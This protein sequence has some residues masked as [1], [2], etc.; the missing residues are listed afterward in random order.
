MLWDAESPVVPL[1]KVFSTVMA[2]WAERALA[3]LVVEAFCRK[4]WN[5]AVDSEEPVMRKLPSGLRRFRV[6]R[7]SKT[8]GARLP[9]ELIRDWPPEPVQNAVENWLCAVRWALA[10]S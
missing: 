1:K 6:C 2:S 4:L 9:P 3:M 10:K 8:A 7:A 5:A